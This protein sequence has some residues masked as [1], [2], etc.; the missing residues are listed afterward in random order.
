[1][2]ER[3]HHWIDLTFGHKLAGSAAVKSKN[4]CL[5]LVDSHTKISDFGVVQL[6]TQPHPHKITPNPYM[7]KAAPK[8]TV[9]TNSKSIS[10]F[11]SYFT[12]N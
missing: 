4:V 9:P 6:F 8:I 3:L 2:S 10:T 7:E 1:M 11:F 12:E 5:Y